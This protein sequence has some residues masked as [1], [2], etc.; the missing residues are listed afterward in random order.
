M[1]KDEVRE[2]KLRDADGHHNRSTKCR[3]AARLVTNLY[4]DFPQ[5]V[6]QNTLVVVEY[7]ICF[8]CNLLFFS[9]VKKFENRLGFDKVIT[10]S[11]VVHLF[12]DTV[13]DFTSWIRTTS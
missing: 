9:M 1:D 7:L 2:A 11:W 12:W 6:R 8:V 5:V 3:S 10:I 13:G 4:F